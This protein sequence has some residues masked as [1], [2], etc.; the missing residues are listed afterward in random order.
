MIIRFVTKFTFFSPFYIYSA[1][2][3]KETANTAIFEINF[4]FSVS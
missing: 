3:L 4:F 2:Y 1:K